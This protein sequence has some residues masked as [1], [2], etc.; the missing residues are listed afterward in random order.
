MPYIGAS[1]Y[2]KKQKFDAYRLKGVGI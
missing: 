1:V 2:I